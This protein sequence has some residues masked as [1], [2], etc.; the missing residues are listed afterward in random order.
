MA[1]QPTEHIKIKLHRNVQNS[2]AARQAA[3]RNP[4]PPH[5]DFVAMEVDRVLQELGEIY[6]KS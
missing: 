5:V 3:D 6:E 4:Q 1:A 2:G